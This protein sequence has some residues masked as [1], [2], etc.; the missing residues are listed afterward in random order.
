MLVALVLALAAFLGVVVLMPAGLSLGAKLMALSFGLVGAGD[1]WY[2][3]SRWS[4][5][6][7]DPRDGAT[8]PDRST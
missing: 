1:F 3:Y 5:I 7:E 2:F 6:P 8:L 4:A